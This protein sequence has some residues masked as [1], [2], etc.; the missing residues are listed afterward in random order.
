[1]NY[2]F[3][4]RK[5]NKCKTLFLFYFLLYVCNKKMK[6]PNSFLI[7]NLIMGLSHE[8]SLSVDLNYISLLIEEDLLQRCVT[9]R[10]WHYSPVSM[11]ALGR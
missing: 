10:V 8:V 11:S 6:S 4:V 7:R 5:I 1:M 3:F 2:R 9:F